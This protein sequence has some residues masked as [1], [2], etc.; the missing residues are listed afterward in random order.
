MVPITESLLFRFI[1]LSTTWEAG[2][3]KVSDAAQNRIRGDIS[4][5]I[6]VIAM[7]VKNIVLRIQSLQY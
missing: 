1:V 5:T 2:T 4:K 6:K 7:Q 3:V